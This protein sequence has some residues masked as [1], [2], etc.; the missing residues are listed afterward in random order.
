MDNKAKIDQLVAQ[1]NDHSYRYHVLDKPIISDAEYD[2]LYRQ[3][4]QLELQHPDLVRDDSPTKRVGGTVLQEFRSVKHRQPMLSLNNAMDIAELENFDGQI[5]RLLKEAD[6]NQIE[7][8]IED[9]FD[10][11]SLQITYED[12]L[13]VQAATRGDGFQGEDVTQNVKT[14]R[15]VPLRLVGKVVPELIEIRGE[16]IFQKKHFEKLNAEKIQAGEEPFANPRNAAAGTLRQLDPKITANRPLSFYAWGIG[17]VQ[18]FDLPPSN[19]EILKKIE[20]FGFVLSPKLQVVRGL[21]LIS[22]LYKEFE[23]QRQNL[24]Y[25]VDGL[26]VKVNSTDLQAQLG[27]RQRSPRWAVALKYAAVEETTTL[28]DIIVQVGRTGAIT[29]VAVLEPVRV[30]GVVVSRATLHNEDEIKRKDLKIGDRVVVRRQGDVIPAVVAVITAARDGTQRDFSFPQEC[31]ECQ[32]K[33]VR[34]DGESAYRCPNRSCPAQLQARLIHFAS[35]DGMDITGLGDKVAALLL[36]SGLVRDVADL[37]DLTIEQLKALP[38]MGEL[39]AKN[40]VE[41]I[42]QSKKVSLAKFIF[43]LGVRHVGEHSAEEVAKNVKS[44]EGFLA[45]TTESILAINGIGPEIAKSLSDFIGDPQERDTIDRLR[46]AG[47]VVEDFVG[48]ARALLAGKTFVITG[49]LTSLSRKDAE[50]KI[51]ALSGS[52]SGSVSAKTS[53]VVVGDEPGSKFE[54]AKQLG[55]SILNES[56]FLTLV[57]N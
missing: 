47:V 28:L 46:N 16:V 44:L 10:G 24:P 54:K 1:L 9:K 53:Y 55:I 4:E 43:A 51:K 52:V 30:G 18:G 56:E 13:L 26:V 36:E 33:I 15:S 3:L 21:A 17:E 8:T 45:L 34:A 57:N 41:A 23:E 48:V 27:F 42:Q 29:P 2:R 32:T 12:G 25:E 31:P 22:K 40:L 37:Y 11:T 14:I 19:Y 38:R 49:T 39:S 20:Q 35:R 50:D 7:Y 6:A 5:K